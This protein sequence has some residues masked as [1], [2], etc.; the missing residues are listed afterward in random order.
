MALQVQQVEV[1]L[2]FSAY[3]GGTSCISHTDDKSVSYLPSNQT[4]RSGD[5]LGQWF[6]GNRSV[7][8][9]FLHDKV[10]VNSQPRLWV[11]TNEVEFVH[12]SLLAYPSNI[13]VDQLQ[14]VFAIS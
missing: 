7:L 13:Q 3:H 12:L 8:P 1:V 2:A 6:F 9:L 10:E 4:N 11:A 5:K 14:Q